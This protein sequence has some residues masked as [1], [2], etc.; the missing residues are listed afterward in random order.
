MKIHKQGEDTWAKDRQV[1]ILTEFK[2]DGRQY[3]VTMS[4]SSQMLQGLPDSAFKNV[5]HDKN[6]RQTNAT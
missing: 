5:H 1:P 2:S 4:V 3:D 6:A